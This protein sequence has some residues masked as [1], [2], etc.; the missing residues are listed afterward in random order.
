MHLG[1]G[2]FHRAHQAVYTDD[3]LAKDPGWAIVG[4]SLRSSE[5]R[6]ALKP[7]DGLYTLAV[8]SGEGERLRVI[9]SVLDVLVA[10]DERERLLAAMADPRIR[11][12]SLTVTEKGYCHDPATGA[13]NEAHP[14]IVHD[15]GDPHAPRTAPGLIVEALARRRAAG[16]TPFTVLTLRQ[17][18]GERPPG[19][20]ARSTASRRSAIPTSARSSPVRLS[21][22][23]RWSTASR[24]PP[25]MRTARVSRRRSASPIAWPVV[26]EP[27]SQWV[28]EDRFAAGRPPWED[29]GAELVARRRAL[30]ADE[31]P[32]PE[33]RAFEPCLSR[34]SRRLRDRL[35]GDGRRRLRALRAKL[36]E[37]VTPTLSV[38]PSTDL[39]AYKRALIERFKNPALK[40]R[41]WQI[42]MDGSQKLPQRLLGTIRDCLKRGAP[43]DR[44]ALGVAAWMR[45]VT[46]IDEKGKAIDVRDP[47]AARLRD[48]ADAAGPDAKR[49]APALLAV[50]RNLRQ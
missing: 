10:P 47:L 25:P 14:D 26:T 5:T 38:P 9:G 3:I 34:L 43:F 17:S 46:G 6:D 1:I 2:A 24:R 12:V 49:L 27:F 48:I 11:I 36:M 20:A 50:E 45:Y 33:R 35:G 44:L 31:A 37:E 21:A 4:A 18:S 30:R 8:R 42:A 40:H 7:Q 15:L 13:L 22:R 39:A 16:V 32:A 29:A 28:I 23:R 19:E 41:T